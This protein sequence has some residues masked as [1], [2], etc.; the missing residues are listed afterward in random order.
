MMLLK[1]LIILSATTPFLVFSDS[2]SKDGSCVTTTFKRNVYCIGECVFFYEE[3]FSTHGG[4]GG[5]LKEGSYGS[6]SMIS[7]P[8]YQVKTLKGGAGKITRINPNTG[9]VMITI[10]TYITQDRGEKKPKVVMYSGS[11]ESRKNRKRSGNKWP[12]SEY[13]WFKSKDLYKT[14]PI[15]SGEV[16]SLIPKLKCND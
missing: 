15:T 8:S 11:R 16:K 3:E 7:D 6:S 13:D 1:L 10:N 12:M 4:G 5:Q 9:E 14:F 2:V